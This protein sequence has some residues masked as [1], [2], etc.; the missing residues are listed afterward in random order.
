MKKN[1]DLQKFFSLRI[2][3][4][5]ICGDAMNSRGSYYRRFKMSYLLI[6]LVPILVLESVNFFFFREMTFDSVR[7]M[8]N[9]EGHS[10]LSQIDGQIENIQWIA[11]TYRRKPESF[12]DCQTDYVSTVF[13]LKD[14][15]EQDGRW[16]A[17]FSRIYYYNSDEHYA[18]YSDGAVDEDLLFSKLL[19]TQN[20][21]DGLLPQKISSGK[22]DFFRAR[23]IKYGKSMIAAAAALDWDS[24]RS[25]AKS[26]LIFTV[27]TDALAQ[28][29]SIQVNGSAAKAVL[30]CNGTQIYSTDAEWDAAISAG[31]GVDA[32]KM[33]GAGSAVTLSSDSGMQVE[34][35]IPYGVFNTR[36]FGTMWKQLLVLLAVLVAGFAFISRGMERNYQPLNKVY[37]T[38]MEHYGKLVNNREPAVGGADEVESI[39]RVMNALLYSK[40]FLQQSNRELQCETLLLALLENRVVPGS[41]L[42]G[43]CLDHGIRIDRN[44][45]L[46]VQME[47]KEENAELFELFRRKDAVPET[48]SYMLYFDE[49][50]YIVMFCSDLAPDRLE[51]EIRSACLEKGGRVCVGSAFGAI[52]RA[53]EAYRGLQANLALELDRAFNPRDA[54]AQLAQAAAKD[55]LHSMESPLSELG[56]FFEYG[57]LPAVYS[58]FL[59]ASR[60]LSADFSEVSGACRRPS[61]GRSVRGSLKMHLARFYEQF[62]SACGTGRKPEEKLPGAAPQDGELAK[63]IDYIEKHYLD[64]NFSVKSLAAEFGKTPSCL[65]HF[66][67]KAAKRNLSQYIEQ[68]K[69]EKA[70]GMLSDGRYKVSEVAAVLGFSGSSAFAEAFKRSMGMTPRAYLS[71]HK[72]DGGAEKTIFFE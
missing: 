59:E 11:E 2:R 28:L 67:K 45:F 69:M 13:K 72:A 44:S 65:S 25:R 64:T 26:S 6:L 24:S 48:D 35:F 22:T 55:D 33:R 21:Q 5:E 7:E 61:A 60:L 56:R 16:F 23:N 53:G 27:N 29:L 54:L 4:A 8:V 32:E 31:N 18:V 12:L 30:S 41:A 9:Q 47:D 38:S 50:Y 57:E 17:F 70:C 37:Q 46:Y 36:I 58:A 34:Y 66:F 3:K 68:L 43:A 10:R 71:S 1:G 63:I 49:R 39:N 15:L 62:K 40:D 52:D 51:S 42:Y 20:T 19:H 14:D